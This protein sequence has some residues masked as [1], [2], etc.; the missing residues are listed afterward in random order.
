MRLS[1]IAL[2]LVLVGCSV[3]PPV[4]IPASEP[5]L[6]GRPD[7]K[8]SRI[9]FFPSATVDGDGV[10]YFYLEL[11]NE[12]GELIDCEPSELLVQTKAGRGVVFKLERILR[13][14]YYLILN[15]RPQADELVLL[16]RGELLST[17]KL[18][19]GRLD[20]SQTKIIRIKTDK[21]KTTFLL[22]LAD[23]HHRPVKL[24]E[25]PEILLEGMGSVKDLQEIS[26]GM[27]EFSV[28]YPEIS[29]IMYFSVRAQGVYH[30]RIFRYH[31]VE[32]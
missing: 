25:R 31:H 28:V 12:L 15:E 23:A 8:R 11:K 1:F 21:N 32:K 9:Q 10:L 6:Y 4:R 30:E 27:W 2:I 26:E 20:P 14:K 16:L 13:G 17:F 3:S 24:V 29:Q 7:L 22:R 5:T 18:P 19:R